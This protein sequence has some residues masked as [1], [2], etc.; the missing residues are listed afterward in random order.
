MIHI[1]FQQ[2]F[3]DFALCCGYGLAQ[4]WVLGI[5]GDRFHGKKPGRELLPRLHS[6]QL[7]I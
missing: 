7:K 6:N 5:E 1:V 4:M 3:T 2:N